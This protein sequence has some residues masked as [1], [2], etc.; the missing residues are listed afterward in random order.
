[1]HAPV[2]GRVDH[3]VALMPAQGQCN[4]EEVGE[5]K[6]NGG[7][8]IIDP[9]SLT[10]WLPSGDAIRWPNWPQMCKHIACLS[11]SVRLM[12]TLYIRNVPPELD[13][14]L[15]AA[16]RA[17]GVSKNRRAIEALRRGLSMDQLDRAELV[18]RIRRDRRPVD[19]D[20][21][22]LIRKERA[23]RGR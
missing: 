5:L 17:A 19:V 23:E 18:E 21:A 7:G 15:D 22:E 4:V 2:S 20:V 13:A 6:T 10:I 14:A 16:A 9:P 12:P 1:M 3:L 11:A 8:P